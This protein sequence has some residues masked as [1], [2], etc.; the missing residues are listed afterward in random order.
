MVKED[1][2]K[3]F[4]AICF[5]ILLSI[6]IIVGLIFL[7]LPPCPELNDP[8]LQIVKEDKPIQVPAINLVKIPQKYLFFNK[9]IYLNNETLINMVSLFE[10]AKK[11]E[12][13]L[14]LVYGYR[15]NEQQK[16]L[17]DE[18]VQKWIK[19]GKTIKEAENLSKTIVAL[20]GESEHQ[21]GT[22]IDIIEKHE[23]N[24]YYLSENAKN[25]L[26]KEAW[27]FGF[28]LSYPKNKTYL[29]DIIYE[30]WHWRYIGKKYAAELYQSNYLSLT[31]NITIRSYLQEKRQCN[32]LKS[33]FK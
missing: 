25:W 29:T 18:E 7:F 33:F 16:E 14:F 10:E 5:L 15:S 19:N 30:P 27:K 28:I 13:N 12:I 6:F 11:Y 26:E 22:T 1:N 2:K 8:L 21:L 20:P 17:Y 4:V 23:N 24:E 3:N 32:Q 31:N 9:E